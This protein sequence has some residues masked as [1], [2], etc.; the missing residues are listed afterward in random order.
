MVSITGYRITQPTHMIGGYAHLAYG[1]N[2]DGTG[3]PTAMS[4]SAVRK[5]KK[6]ELVRWRRQ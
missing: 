5:M 1:F 4:L 2:Y 6:I 3:A